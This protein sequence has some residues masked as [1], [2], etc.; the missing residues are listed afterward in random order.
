MHSGCAQRTCWSACR[1]FL[2]TF[3][4]WCNWQMPEASAYNTSPED[5]LSRSKRRY[6][7]CRRVPKSHGTNVQMMMSSNKDANATFII[8]RLESFKKLFSP[9]PDFIY[10]TVMMIARLTSS[11]A[12]M[13][14]CVASTPVSAVCELIPA[15]K[16]GK[17]SAALTRCKTGFYSCPAG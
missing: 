15:Y 2:C 3:S 6:R 17:L 11:A 16:L 5:M 13:V 7:R 9:S 4:R 8:G 14:A 12:N 10:P 1:H